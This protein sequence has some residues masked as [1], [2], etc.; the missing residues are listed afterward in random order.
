MDACLFA[1]FLIHR[2]HAL[3]TKLLP[4]SP[5]IWKLPKCI[6]MV[7]VGHK[8]NQIS[9]WPDPFGIFQCSVL[10][11]CLPAL[12]LDSAAIAGVVI[13]NIALSVLALE[14]NT[15]WAEGIGDLPLPASLG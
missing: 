9:M 7:T 13:E 8:V 14:I 3:N 11:A 4:S 10:P 5:C 2:Q 1:I 6:L 15:F 12:L